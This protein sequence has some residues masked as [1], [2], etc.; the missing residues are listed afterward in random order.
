MRD[1]GL[2]EPAAVSRMPSLRAIAGLGN[3]G[4]RYERTRHNAGFLVLERLRRA[5]GG[6]WQALPDRD[7]SR[8]VLEDRDLLLLR[9]ATFMNRSGEPLAAAL[10]ENGLRP[11]EMLVVV[12]D[13]VLP[14]GRIRIRRRGGPGGHNGLVS[15]CETFGTE[16]VSRLRV[17]VGPAPPG[18]DLA[19]FVLEPM[20]GEAWLA[21]LAG[22]DLA[23]EAA[24]FLLREGLPA[25]MN[26]Y[27]PAPPADENES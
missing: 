7:E 9:P 25:A 14:T 16:S 4:P 13:V 1:D 17:G 10:A 26:R 8:I 22:C 2:I 5:A 19:E 12:D 23:A 21:L 20:S 6:S 11:E 15:I 18:I 27:N 3:P 24:R